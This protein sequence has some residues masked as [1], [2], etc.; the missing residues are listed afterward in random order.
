MREVSPTFLRAA[1]ARET[2]EAPIV[3][4]TIEHASLTAPIRVAGY[5]VDVTSRGE[6]F[7]ALPFA[8]SLP[9]DT[10]EAAPR[11][12]VSLDNVSREIVIAV[13]GATGKPPSVTLEVVLADTP[14]VVE[15]SWAGF[16][17]R[18]VSYNALTV[19]GELTLEGLAAEPNPAGRFTPGAFPGV[20]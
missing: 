15:A 20:H 3:L 10:E 19:E 7:V 14:D 8:I 11:A 13:R 6:T 12:K 17:L 1:L 16:A 2:G 5:D 9:T 18:N 4:V